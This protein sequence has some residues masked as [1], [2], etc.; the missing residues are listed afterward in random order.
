MLL[1]SIGDELLAMDYGLKR[2][3]WRLV[4]GPWLSFD[5]VLYRFIV[6]L[7]HLNCSFHEL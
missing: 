7:S 2:R 6:D 3:Q 5:A 1:S 4:G